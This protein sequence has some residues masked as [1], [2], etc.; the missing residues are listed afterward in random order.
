MV[1]GSVR[2]DPARE[3][4]AAL[5]EAL[6]ELPFMRG[7]PNRRL[8]IQL[9]RRDGTPVADIQERQ[10]QRLHAVE[11]V[12][13]CL[14]PPAGLRALAGALSVMAPNEP[15][16]LRVQ[17]LVQSA[18][19]Q[20]LLSDAEL[21][22]GRR[23]IRRVLTRL[24]EARRRSS[25]TAPDL[26]S[27]FDE[28]LSRP[29]DDHG[30][31]PALDLATRVADE[32]DDPELRTWIASVAEQ[33][34]VGRPPGPGVST[35]EAPAAEAVIPPPEPSPP[36]GLD[37]L[38]PLLPPECH[39]PSLHPADGGAP[40]ASETAAAKLS[41][42]HDIRRPVIW[43]DVPPRNPQF[44]GREDLLH[45]LREQL[46]TSGHAAVLP[47]ALHGLGGVG[48]SQVAIEYV[49][50]FK[51]TY[52]LIWW[53]PAEHPDQILASLTRLAQRLNLDVGLDASSAVPA[54]R[55][56][57]ST[58]AGPYPSWLL[59]FDNAEAVRDVRHY[60]PAGAGGQILVTARNPEW[61]L[62]AAS[63]EIDV[64]SRVESVALLTRRT[65][66]LR[67]EEADRLAAALG[68]LPL[69][70]DQAAAW[71]A[72]T[73]MAVDEYL[74]LLDQQR[75][76]LFD[77]YPP[78]IETSVAAAWNVSLDRLADVHPA[79]LHLLQV[80]A[81]FAPEPISLALFAGSPTAP[82][83]DP[84]DHALDDSI[85]LGRVIREIKRYALARLDHHHQTLQMHRIVQVVLI[86]RMTP[87]ERETMRGG[88]HTLLANGDPKNP[89]DA[90]MW[91]RYQAM[92]PHLRVSRAVESGDRR[93]QDLVLGTVQ[94]LFHWGDHAGCEEL[95]G[96]AY[97]VRLAHLG[98]T[99]P[100][101]LELATWLGSVKW[102]IGK[103]GEAAELNRRSLEHY[104]HNFG[105][106]DEGTLRAMH[107]VAADLRSAGEFWSARDMD[108]HAL[109]TCN[110]SFGP[111][112]PATLAAA[113]ALA[114]DLRLTGE[115]TVAADLDNDTYRRRGDLFGDNA[116]ATLSTRNSLAIDYCG[117]GQYDRARRLAEDVYQRH[118][119]TFGP[120]APGAL[121]AA[122][123]L[124]VARRCGGDHDAARRLAKDT[125]ERIQ[126]RY[127][128][129]YP[130]GMAAALALSV[131]MRLHGEL[132]DA[133]ELNERT[134]ARYRI[135]FHPTHPH[136]LSARVNLAVVQ[137]L[138]G[139]VELARRNDDETLREF[140]HRL[141]PDHPS[142]LACA[143]NLASD[144]LLLGDCQH[145]FERD[146]D[147]VARSTRVLGATHPSTLACN[148]N[149]AL[150]LRLLGRDREAQ[151][152]HDDTVHRYRQ[153][154]GPQHPATVNAEQYLRADCEIDPL[155]L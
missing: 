66:D 121:R 46:V 89:S 22:R 8:F 99:S 26:L 79:A 136:T 119:D 93:V 117:I 68:D 154:L 85:R 5:V 125:V 74:R 122:R 40:N 107:L 14:H 147:T 45:L 84:L 57:L 97:A 44:T 90:A 53:I 12:M 32:T 102:T 108:Q 95:A 58:G 123:T 134:V 128:D 152:I 49:H 91:P 20:S 145:A 3:L 113:H 63:L 23:L 4:R 70:L 116:E 71:C 28:L 137:R 80:C 27:D 88:A 33:V 149:L 62:V 34:G 10:E 64:F 98:E 155:P 133:R 15:Q 65:P 36:P 142:T 140:V 129:E 38:P 17:H 81:F 144:E 110:R 109:A 153:S 55:E 103:Y 72:A 139:D 43:G 60:F 78:N 56:A 6:V 131:E 105:E 86:G 24:P 50:R 148:L 2:R 59:V 150:D 101:T 115:F 30:M 67:T 82:I 100:R 83:T 126:R 75:L 112:D 135:V 48:K 19:L 29:P 104:R 132:D 69:A 76:E 114:A 124:A 54:V 51:E 39:D 138:Q 143:V 31:P 21:D 106:D 9:I 151:V 18:P 127:G 1:S 77:D 52:D 87:A 37:P 25:A 118:V 92:L 141:G 111:D 16:A 11:I 41:R 94:F 35:T 130:E 120:D 61:A 96:E 7:L 42:E 146:T 13:A 47:R 73:G